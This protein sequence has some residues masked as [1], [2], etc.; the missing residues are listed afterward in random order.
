[1]ND[2]NNLALRTLYVQ[3]RIFT[4]RIYQNKLPPPQICTLFGQSSK[5][6]QIFWV[7]ESGG[8]SWNGVFIFFQFPC[9]LLK[10][11][12][13]NTLYLIFISGKTNKYV[14]WC[15]LVTN[16]RGGTKLRAVAI[17]LFHTGF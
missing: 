6:K 12:V 2:N 13:R 15:R 7:E 16:V 1:M 17:L 3:R 4:Y 8:C 14:D 9:A 11:V 10:Q 5:S